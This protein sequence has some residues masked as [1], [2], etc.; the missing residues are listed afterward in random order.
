MM[1]GENRTLTCNVS[2]SPVQTVT[3]T[4]NKNNKI[5]SL[6]PKSYQANYNFRKQRNFNLNRC[7]TDRAATSFINMCCRNSL[8]N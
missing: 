7:K 3:W 1:E 4:E 6:I 5:H 2:G 8:Y